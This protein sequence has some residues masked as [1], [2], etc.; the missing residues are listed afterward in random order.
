MPKVSK[1]VT[2]T[3]TDKEIR[4]LILEDAKSKAKVDSLGAS[5]IVLETV[6]GDAA[7]HKTLH[8][9]VATVSL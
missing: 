9:V 6:A 1:S 8:A 2:V 5:T 4:D 7:D 3:Y